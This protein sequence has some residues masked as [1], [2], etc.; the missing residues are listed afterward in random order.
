MSK[1]LN[2]VRLNCWEFNNC[3]REPGG[4]NSFMGVCPAAIAKNLEGLNHGINAGRICWN[5]FGTF[6]CVK[7]INSCNYSFCHKISYCKNCEF[8][9]L[10]Q[11]EEGV[12][13][14]IYP[15]KRILVNF[16]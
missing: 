6:C 3:G 16:S 8:F 7:N 5:I 4:K 1:K 14:V 10:V 13:F 15:K 2:I 12:N 9:K 11:K